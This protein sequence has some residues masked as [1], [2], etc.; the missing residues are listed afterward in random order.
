MCEYVK[1]YAVHVKVTLN[2]ILFVFSQATL[3]S[4]V[5]IIFTEGTQGRL[6]DADITR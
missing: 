5:K 2:T 6:T 3:S 1:L 4:L